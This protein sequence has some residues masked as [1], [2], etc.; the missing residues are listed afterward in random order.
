MLHPSPGSALLEVKEVLF[1][2]C[3]WGL[4]KGQTSSSKIFSL[5]P[6]ALLQMQPLGLIG[7]GL[8]C[9]DRQGKEADHIDLGDETRT[10]LIQ[11]YLPV[12]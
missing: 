10:K 3:C 8:N 5:F 2:F 12:V 7:Q 1:P 4:R 11:E 6:S 9:Q